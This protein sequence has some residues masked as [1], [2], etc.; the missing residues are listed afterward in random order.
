MP[1]YNDAF[2]YVRKIQI[3]RNVRPVVVFF[4]DGTLV[5]IESE[6]KL[7]QETK[8]GNRIILRRNDS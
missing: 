2:T 1:D 4:K 3:N 5:M 8:R 7:F 6:L